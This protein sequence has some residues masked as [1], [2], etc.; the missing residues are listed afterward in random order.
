MNGKGE[1][2]TSS[3]RQ[4]T[5]SPPP[6]ENEIKSEDGYPIDNYEGE[7]FKNPKEEGKA[8]TRI[9]C[10]TPPLENETKSE[11]EELIIKD[12]R[13]LS[14]NGEGELMTSSVVVDTFQ[15]YITKDEVL[16]KTEG[17]A[18]PSTTAGNPPTPHPPIALT[19]ASPNLLPTP[20]SAPFY[21]TNPPPLVALS[22]VNAKSFVQVTV[23][24]EHSTTWPEGSPVPEPRRVYGGDIDGGDD[25]GD[26]SDGD[27]GKIIDTSP[28]GLCIRDL[29]FRGT[30]TAFDLV[31]AV[32]VAFGLEVEAA[33][34][35]PFEC[36]SNQGALHLHENAMGMYDVW[37]NKTAFIPGVRYGG[38]EIDED[39]PGPGAEEGDNQE[40]KE[41]AGDPTAAQPP[42]KK[43]RGRRAT[44][45]PGT[46]PLGELK[47]FKIVQLLDKP[48]VT[49]GIE[50]PGGVRADIALDLLIPRRPPHASE[51][52][53]ARPP[54]CCGPTEGFVAERTAYFF[55]VRLGAM[56]CRYHLLSSFQ[57]SMAVRCVEARG[58]AYG[59]SH[60]DYVPGDDELDTPEGAA[61]VDLINLRYNAG[62]QVRGLLS[63]TGDPDTDF[64]QVGRWMRAPLF[65]IEYFSVGNGDAAEQKVAE[66]FNDR[67]MKN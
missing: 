38:R 21:P 16:P 39:Q 34:A 50:R 62:R 31:K 14:S 13:V 10:G 12:D 27:N 41:I 52:T 66:P 56:G 35:H 46:T 6:L 61:E 44:R 30:A 22:E 24:C 43:R 26:S 58:G 45:L 51:L 2:L 3:G 37:D 67:W 25:N 59:G 8:M 47:R 49:T 48:V 57:E 20:S 11:A 17:I 60:I 36:Q 5:V 64:Y 40:P 9:I 32:L 15:E 28:P 1:A 63:G 54:P 23:V 18:P 19:P 55:R 33:K 29:V 7:L 53:G 4:I 42:P 65:N